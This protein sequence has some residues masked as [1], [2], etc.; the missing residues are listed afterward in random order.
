MDHTAFEA[1]LQNDFLKR[2]GGV[3]PKHLKRWTGMVDERHQRIREVLGGDKVDMSIAAQAVRMAA[4]GDEYESIVDELVSTFPH[5]LNDH[6]FD[7]S[8]FASPTIPRGN[9]NAVKISKH[10]LS[11]VRNRTQDMPSGAAR[12]ITEKMNCCLSKL[13]A[14][15]GK[16]SNDEIRAIVTISTS[17]K[18]FVLLG[19]YGP[20]KESCFRQGSDK[21]LDKFVIGQSDET[22][23]ATVSVP[24][25]KHPDR[26]KNIAR[27]IG[28]M[29]H[30]R[31][32]FNTFNYYFEPGFAE[33]NAIALFT[34]AFGQILGREKCRFLENIIGIAPGVFVNEYAR[35]TFDF[36]DEP[37]VPQLLEPD[38]NGIKIFVCPKCGRKHKSDDNWTDIDGL[39]VC[40]HCAMHAYVCEV[41][42]RPTFKPLVEVVD[43]GG[44]FVL[45]HPDLASGM[46][47]CGLCSHSFYPR[48]GTIQLPGYPSD[49]CTAC[50]DDEAC[51]CEDCGK[52]IGCGDDEDSWDR[53]L[54]EDCK[55]DHNLD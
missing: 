43:H 22:F 2:N 50:F 25:E 40:D 52:I 1:W 12:S 55:R 13:G 46:P 54:C 15:W 21:T 47:R 51:V 31:K 3:A 32:I 30:N 41:S 7:R 17:P 28:F 44:N 19:H 48:G 6:G 29:N 18:G 42:G 53:V 33:G 36:S 45:V 14:V 10:F 35:W 34:K 4:S 49:I 37:T 26:H 16:S 8:V 11:Y 38:Q 24:H 9:H 23:V 39:L 27:A 5:Y 20:D